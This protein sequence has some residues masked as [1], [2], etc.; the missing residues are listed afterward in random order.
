MIKMINQQKRQKLG[1]VCLLISPFGGVLRLK[2]S[3]IH[4]KM[5]SGV[6]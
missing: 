3:L 5:M 1:G 6:N 2:N 4:H